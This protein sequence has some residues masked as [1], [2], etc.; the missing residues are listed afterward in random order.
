MRRSPT[1]AAAPS[2]A[3]REALRQHLLALRGGTAGSLRDRL[4]SAVPNLE[5]AVDNHLASLAV[6]RAPDRSSVSLR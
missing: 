6:A 1:S 4:A 2:A 3:S 5:G